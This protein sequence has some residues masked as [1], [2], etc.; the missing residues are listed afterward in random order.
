MISQV[1]AYISY[2]KLLPKQS[3]VIVGLSGGPDSMVLIHIL[4][5]LG[6]ECIAA[7]CNFHLRG[8]ASNNDAEFV[9]KWCKENSIPLN[10]IGFDTDA[11]ASQKKISIEMAARD[12]RYDWF[13]KLRI[14][15]DADVIAIA[16]HRDDSVETILIN[17]IRGTGIKGLT[18]IP[19]KNKHIVRPLLAVS[20]SEIME[21]VS[22]HQLP[23]VVDETNNEDIY[24]RNIIRLKVL[25]LLETI[26]PSVRNSIIT[27]SCNLKEV[28]KIYN[29]Y[30]SNMLSAVLKDYRIDIAQLKKTYSP[31]SLLF[32]ILTPL[33]F[34]PS[35]IE[36]ISNNIDSIPGKVYLSNEYRL[37]KD[38][39]YLI[40]TE[41]ETKQIKNEVYLIYPHTSNI[42]TPFSMSINTV[43]NDSNFKLEKK[44]TKLHV[45]FDK[46]SFPLILRKW[47][48]GD[49][50]VPFGMT[51]KK[52]IS[53]FFTDN[54]FNLIDKE[55]TWILISGDDVVWIVNHRV[56]NR[57]KIEN[58]TKTIFLIDTLKQ[59]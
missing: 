11:Y 6:Y 4:L 22:S 54:K 38:R 33:R 30:I 7:H 53:D 47:K 21:Y 25:P 41:I 1:Q 58:D 40:I 3:K 35:V 55:A 14:K 17:L 16:H 5:Q 51:G 26:N 10:V 50:F 49:W 27:T 20:R 8:E 9:F 18:G 52:K 39:E 56:D 19:I 12:L 45:D 2:H 46:L 32:E 59:S 43:L 48:K 36:D 34:T 42:N 28:E 24:T 23:Y 44:N 13:E 37:L 31:K 29:N 15:H 57:F